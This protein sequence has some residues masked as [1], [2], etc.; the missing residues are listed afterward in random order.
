MALNVNCSNAITSQ[1]L[2]ILQKRSRP[3]SVSDYEEEIKIIKKSIMRIFIGV[4]I[5]IIIIM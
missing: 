3:H 5:N 1:C 2:L 4:Y